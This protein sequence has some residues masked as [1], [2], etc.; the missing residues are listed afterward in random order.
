ML[1]THKFCTCVAGAG[2]SSERVSG[3]A[4]H[5]G[6]SQGYLSASRREQLHS[7]TIEVGKDC[8]AYI[9]IQMKTWRRG[10]SLDWENNGTHLSGVCNLSYLSYC[11]T[12]RIYHS[13]KR[14]TATLI[15]LREFDWRG[16]RDDL[17]KLKILN[18]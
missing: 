14:Q 18:N 4:S 15:L 10:I 3:N 1:L 9:I 12:S 13:G 17:E 5:G 2:S 16:G 6:S 11:F 8:A 7:V